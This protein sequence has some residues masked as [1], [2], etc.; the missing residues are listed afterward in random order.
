MAG[1]KKMKY[2]AVL[3]CPAIIFNFFKKR[4]NFGVVFVSLPYAREPYMSGCCLFT[5]K[6]GS[7]GMNAALEPNTQLLQYT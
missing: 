1:M 7:P 4:K 5:G 2:V 3:C 6:D